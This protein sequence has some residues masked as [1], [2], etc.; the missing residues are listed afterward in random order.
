MWLIFGILAIGATLT[1]LYLCRSGKDYR[2]FMALGL[3]LT[4]LTLC[5]EYAQIAS[6]TMTQDWYAIEDVAPTMS[7]VLWVLTGVSI[8]LNL[9][10]VA[11]DKFSKK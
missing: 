11:L 6:W 4:A 8:A 10:P 3:S 2:L 1:N 7:K 5:A 9:F